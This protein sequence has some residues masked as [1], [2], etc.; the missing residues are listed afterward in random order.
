MEKVVPDGMAR[1]KILNLLKP[2]ENAVEDFLKASLVDAELIKYRQSMIVFSLFAAILEIKL[3]QMP[4][5]PYQNFSHL[6]AFNQ[7]FDRI[8]L[9]VY[10]D[11]VMQSGQE[12]GLPYLDDF[13]RYI[14]LRQKKIYGVF[15][16]TKSR[17]NHLYNPRTIK[18]FT[19]NVFDFVIKDR[20]VRAPSRPD[21][22]N[23]H[24]GQQVKWNLISDVRE[25][26]FDVNWDF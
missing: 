1:S 15:G 11:N 22:I 12:D 17:I 21:S 24:K 9:E 4:I 2:I 10:G 19:D 7:V 8:S 18:M 23:I 25:Q 26:V 5:D 14:I 20:V 16:N 13:G 3:R 6:R